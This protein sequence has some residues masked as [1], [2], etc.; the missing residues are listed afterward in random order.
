MLL[1]YIWPDEPERLEGIAH[2]AQ[3]AAAH[4]APIECASA[5]AWLATALDQPRPEMLTVLWQSVV[6]QYLD[7]DERATIASVFA[8]AAAAPL[9]WLTLEP[10]ADPSA[11]DSFE[12][13]CR[14][15]P[16]VNGSGTAR[17]IAHA[18]YH[19]PPVVWQV[20]AAD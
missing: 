13:R 3:V 14:E 6:N 8:S 10:P 16:E 7:R 11:T 19:G 12:L 1:S 18:G 4:P 2:A 17:L 5:A 9:A 15:R 20:P